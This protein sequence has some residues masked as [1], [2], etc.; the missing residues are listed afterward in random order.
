MGFLWLKGSVPVSHPS[1]FEMLNYDVFILNIKN[2]SQLT[3]QLLLLDQDK[4]E[5]QISFRVAIRDVWY[6]ILSQPHYIKH[7]FAPSHQQ[8]T[9]RGV[10]GGAWLGHHRFASLR[11]NN[12]VSVYSVYSLL[13]FYLLCSQRN[14]LQGYNMYASLCMPFFQVEALETTFKYYVMILSV[15]SQ[16]EKPYSYSI[17]Y[18]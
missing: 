13:P 17:L 5:S 15:R 11:Q 16:F 10:G 18:T 12:K 4:N 9:S 1:F 2:H 14:D 7:L 3:N 8:A 6:C